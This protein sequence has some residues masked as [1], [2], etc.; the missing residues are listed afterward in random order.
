MRGNRRSVAPLLQRTGPDGHRVDHVVA[1]W[2]VSITLFVV[3]GLVALTIVNNINYLDRT[4]SIGGD[5]EPESRLPDNDQGRP[6]L[7]SDAPIGPALAS[8]SEGNGLDPPLGIIEPPD[9]PPHIESGFD[10]RSPAVNEGETCAD[11]GA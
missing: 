11:R 1:G 4:T 10:A 8:M 2:V 3:C 5:V 7:P 9:V 6:A